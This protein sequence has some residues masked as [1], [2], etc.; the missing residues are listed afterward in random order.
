[1]RSNGAAQRLRHAV[2]AAGGTVPC[3]LD[4]LLRQFG[5]LS[6][7]AQELRIV[8]ESLAEAGVSVDPGLAGGEPSSVVVLR[9]ARPAARPALEPGPRRRDGHVA[10]RPAG[11]ATSDVMG[12]LRELAPVLVFV[13]LGAAL[14][15][16]AIGQW[17]APSAA[18]AVRARAEALR[19]SQSAAYRSAFEAGKRRARP[20]GVAIGEG[21][22]RVVGVHRGLRHGKAQA[23]ANPPPPPPSPTPPPTTVRPSGTAP[24]P[25]VPGT[26]GPGVGR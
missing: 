3:Q 9:A 26:S 24:T 25:Q 17:S 22:G 23:A 15:G 11:P 5:V 14:V 18:D 19:D 1:V 7:T 12:N 2:E 8:E 6:N 10:G 4:T 16:Y 13:A 21:R 20:K